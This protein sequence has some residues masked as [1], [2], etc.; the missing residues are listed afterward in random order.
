MI[1]KYFFSLLLIIIAE[2]SVIAQISFGP[3]ASFNYLKGN[4]ATGLS[5]NWMMVDYIPTGWLAGNAPFRYGTG[6]NGGTVLS[7][8]KG[9]YSTVYFRSTFNAQNI[10][11]LKDVLFSVNFNDGFIV[12]INGEEVF[13]INAPDS[14]TNTSTASDQHRSGTFETYTLPAHDLS[15]NEGENTIAIQGFNINA[16]NVDF[17][18]D[19]GISAELILPQTSDSLKVTFSQ[20]SGFYNS[21]FDLQLNVPDPSYDIIYTIDGT[22][23]QSSSTALNGGKSK[24]ITVNPT[25]IAG[26]AK[27]PCYIVRASL[28]KPGLDPSFPYTQTY[29]FLDQV[30]TQTKPGGDW[31][32]STSVNG[33]TI[34]LEMDPDITTSPK[35][36]GLMISS[37]TAIPSISV[38]TNIKDLFDPTTGIYVNAG[39]HGD[40]WERMC[41]V[42][43]INPSGEPGFNIN[44][45]LRIRGGWSR[46]GNYPKHAFRL[47]FRDEYGASKLK[48]PLF[49][50]EGVDEFDKID[51]RCEQNY[52]WAHPSDDK[53]RN[54][55]VREVFSRDTQ[56]DMGQPYTRSR[57]YHLYLNG[58]YWGLY[59]TQER[60]EARYASSYFGGSKDDYDVIKVNTEDYNYH[61]E[62]TDGNMTSW[63]KIYESSIKGYTNNA[64]YFALEGKDQN[65]NPKKGGEVMLNM[66]N[67]IDYMQVIFYTGN[68]DSPTSSFGGNTGPNNFYAIDKRDDRSQ[69]FIFFTHD[70][71]HTLMIGPEP[72]PNGPGIGIQENR[73]QINNMS[74][75]GLT[76]FHPQWLHFKLSS[77]AEYKMRFADRV[78]KQFFNNGVFTVDAVTERLRKRVTE[79]TGAVVSESA[80]WGDAQRAIPYTFEDWDTE[81]K[82]LYN[83][84]FPLR[85][86][87][88]LNQLK[89]AGLYP[90]FN[91]P[92]L[93]K[94]NT[95]LSGDVYSVNGSY[96]VTLSSP[97]GQIFYTLDGTDPRLIGGL[98]N[99][100][101]KEIATGGTLTLNGTSL[102]KSRVKS[103]DAWSALSSV[104][105]LNSTEDYTNLKVTELHYHPADSIAGS[106]IISGK[107]FEFIELKNTG[108][109]PINLS[110]LNFTSSITYQFK[111]NE[112][113]APKQ[114][115][116]IA[117]KPKWFYERHFM[118]PS[119]NFG[120]NFSN[121]GEQVTIAQSDGNPI[122]SFLYSTANPWATLP[123]GAGNSLT[124]ALR[125]PT[126][127]PN[128]STYWTSSTVYD[129]SPFADDPG[130]T[131]TID[132]LHITDNSITIYPNP[133]KGILFLKL[134][135]VKSNVQVEIYSLSGSLFYESSI[136]GNSVINLSRLNI[137]PGIYLV[138]TKCNNQ[139]SVHK[140][141]YQP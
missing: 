93:K 88:V 34:D 6:G 69:G 99:T 123:N 18:L 27:T 71:E 136:F 9:L 35:Y 141:I 2:F 139:T 74:I 117:S 63:Q 29:I 138:K 101:A 133:T 12:W 66:D 26:R 96:E 25:N 56:R 15:L 28:Q 46:H 42:E 67:L 125:N 115:Y 5:A 53:A 44:A 129:G 79:V 108:D 16:S 30:I 21:P 130:I 78:Y 131:D 85:T 32:S 33:Q 114:F 19:F 137:Y 47:F 50:T 58:M 92:T 83:Q 127:D 106:E 36:S 4:D 95:I 120:K 64:D 62:A 112:V 110:G 39:S 41:S 134:G 1:R 38:V 14:L 11:S 68:F 104:K 84:Y 23:P 81:I 65:G 20:P 3:A 52:S 40:T 48:F 116:V 126:G 111:D 121:S 10:T 55:F 72:Q 76:G 51:L 124:S 60:A 98:V 86:D 82:S 22:N 91:P 113:L 17:Y 57:Y 49:E 59:Q 73:V 13:R 122:I 77:N 70:A 89:K 109:K 100:S 94:D 135:N 140:V 90:A 105:F 8:M 37:L 7:D 132:N 102:I 107:S 103:G 119:G 24:T 80:R 118:I 61:T 43:L 97:A 31:P 87:I 75:S 54:S 45:G 128:E